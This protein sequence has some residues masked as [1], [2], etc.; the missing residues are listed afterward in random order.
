MLSYNDPAWD[1]FWA[2]C[3]DNGI[4]LHTHANGSPIFDFGDHPGSL[5]ITLFEA[6]GWM[7]RRA[8]WH[9]IYGQVF[10]RFPD[11]VLVLTEVEELWYQ[12]TQ[13]S[14]DAAYH[15]FGQVPLRKGR[16]S[17]YFASNVYYGSSFM[18]PEQAEDAW[19]NGY[20]TNVIWG[21]DYPHMEGCHQA[22][23][24]HD[25]PFCRL[26]LRNFLSRVPV[27]EAL[28]LAGANG[29]RAL[30][31]DG[32][33]LAEVARR[34]DAPTITQ[35]R[36]PLDAYPEVPPLSMAF[37]GHAGP[38]HPE[39]DDLAHFTRVNPRELEEFASRTFK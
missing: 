23:G 9:L 16:P 4:T 22:R 26:A 6:G 32:G 21:R 35:L 27:E 28:M 1:P 10:D 37:S 39:L 24:A 20:A 29:V 17:A 31:L 14:L 3:V 5:E 33:Y 36:T 8:P 19:R 7:S 18:S 12:T 13:W 15:R 38:H 30:D 2:A 11:L 34:I 25:E